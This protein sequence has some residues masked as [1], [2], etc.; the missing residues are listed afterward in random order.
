M[1]ILLM[2]NEKCRQGV[3]AWDCFHN[4]REKEFHNFFQRAL[5]IFSELKTYAEKTI[6]I[7]FLINCYHNIEDKIVGPECLRLVS[8]PLWNMLS[9][10]RR[11]FELNGQPLL[12]KHWKRLKKKQ[13]KGSFYFCLNLSYQKEIRL[14]MK[15]HFFQ[16]L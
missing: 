3:P 15:V 5:D 7:V 4:T 10:S 6:F 11:E 16:I 14:I 2:I 13:K 1:S 9:E 12:K 8:L